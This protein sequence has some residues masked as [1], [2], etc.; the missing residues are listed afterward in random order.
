MSKPVALTPWVSPPGFT[1]KHLPVAKI[2]TGGGA[3]WHAKD[4]YVELTNSSTDRETLA[5][6]LEEAARL[7]RATKTEGG[8]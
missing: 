7:I 1:L 6:Q 2:Y 4:L 5:I 3:R 8:A